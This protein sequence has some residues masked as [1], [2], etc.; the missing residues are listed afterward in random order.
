MD[1]SIPIKRSEAGLKS[2]VLWGRLLARNGKVTQI[3]VKQ[4]HNKTWYCRSGNQAATALDA[5]YSRLTA[6]QALL[7]SDGAEASQLFWLTQHFRDILVIT[8]ALP[9]CTRTTPYGS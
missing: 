1:H 2:L 4:L 7:S 5:A 8:A 3:S 9:K 6:C